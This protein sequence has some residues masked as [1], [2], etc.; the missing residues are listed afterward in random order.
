M[1]FAAEQFAYHFAR[2]ALAS[3]RSSQS[4]TISYDACA[5]A[6]RKSPALSFL[7]EL[8]PPRMKYVDSRAAA[9]ATL[10]AANQADDD[11]DM[12]VDG[13]DDDEV[14]V[15]LTRLLAEPFLLCRGAQKYCSH[16]TLE[17]RSNLLVDACTLPGVGVLLAC[18]C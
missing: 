3:R 15:T 4:K 7:A 6:V 17:R 11:D 9:E 13:D 2:K 1:A 16:Q 8:V 10:A 18:D 14:T 5:A 12:D